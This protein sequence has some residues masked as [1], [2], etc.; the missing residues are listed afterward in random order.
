MKMTRHKGILVPATN[1]EMVD[2]K[3]AEL[4]QQ[5]RCPLAWLARYYRSLGRGKSKQ[6]RKKIADQLIA[7]MDERERLRNAKRN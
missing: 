4:V 5:G 7:E 2:K 6:E 3:I 1:K